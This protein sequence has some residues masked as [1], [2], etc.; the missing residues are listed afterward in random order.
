MPAAISFYS[1]ISGKFTKENAEVVCTPQRHEL[2]NT[3]G[4]CY[5]TVHKRGDYHPPPPK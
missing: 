3:I 1:A 4:V 5:V 2:E